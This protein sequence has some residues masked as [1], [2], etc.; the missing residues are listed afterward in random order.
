MQSVILLPYLFLLVKQVVQTE[1]VLVS[2]F[3]V[4]KKQIFCTFVGENQLKANKFWWGEVRWCYR[5][6]M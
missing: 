3:T 1:T 2:Q 4:M 6:L 5:P